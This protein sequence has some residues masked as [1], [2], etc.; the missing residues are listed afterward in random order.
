MNVAITII[1]KRLKNHEIYQQKATDTI[2]NLRIAYLSCTADLTLLPSDMSQKCLAKVLPLDNNK[3]ALFS[4][5]Y[6]SQYS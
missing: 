4:P 1:Q 5:I 3:D 2:L 6:C